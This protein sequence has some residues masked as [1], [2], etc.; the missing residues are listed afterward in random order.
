MILAVNGHHSIQDHRRTLS[1]AGRCVVVGGPLSQIL[2]AILLGP[3]VSRFGGK[4]HVFM[5]I[6]TS[7]RKDL[8]I[9]RKL[10]EAGKL[11]PVIDRYYPLRKTAEAIKYL[12]EE[13]AR[14]KVIITIEHSSAT[15]PDRA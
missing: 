12:I 13:H 1:P 11:T 3:L 8:L 15:A 2:Q 6:T 5:G 9:L 10:L 14:G 4:K 7:S